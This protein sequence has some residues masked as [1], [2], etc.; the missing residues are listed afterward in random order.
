MITPGII[1]GYPPNKL[2][3]LKIVHFEWKL[4]FP[5]KW[6]GL[7]VNL[8]EASPRVCENIDITVEG[9]WIQQLIGMI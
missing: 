1:D 6:Q 9:I 8:G 3:D 2:F 5:K 7:E 4:I